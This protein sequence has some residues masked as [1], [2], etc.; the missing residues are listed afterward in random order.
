MSA[1][2]IEDGP[3]AQQW[4]SAHAPLF[5]YLSEILKLVDFESCTTMTNHPWLDKLIV[6]KAKSLGQKVSVACAALTEQVP[7]HKVAG[8]WY[9][10][11]V[12]CD[13]E[14][15]GVPHRDTNDVKQSMNCVIPWGMWD[16]ADLLF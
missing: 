10:L 2:L 11:V 1:N 3:E 15:S 4:L 5:K 8:I 12:N 14:F 16:G 13:Q 9:G 6:N 7:L